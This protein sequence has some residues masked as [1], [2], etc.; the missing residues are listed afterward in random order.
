MS[1]KY[2]HKNVLFV[3][4]FA[5]KFCPFSEKLMEKV[6]FV[7][8]RKFFHNFRILSQANLRKN[9]CVNERFRFNPSL[10]IL[11]KRIQPSLMV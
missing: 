4:N 5:D 3:S 11:L 1:S 10:G 8:F 6:H 7:N 9:E 2:F